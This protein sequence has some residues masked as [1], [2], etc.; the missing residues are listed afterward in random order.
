MINLMTYDYHGAWETITGH[1]AP[2]YAHPLDDGNVTN[3][4]VV[5]FLDF[6]KT[7]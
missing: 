4:N 7:L 1:N 3:F 2:M 5:R 6:F